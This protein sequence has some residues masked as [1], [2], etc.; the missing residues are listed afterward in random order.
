MFFAL[1]VALAPESA[2]APGHDI[3]Q[4][5]LSDALA[6]I[7]KGRVALAKRQWMDARRAF[8][9]ALRSDPRCCGAHHGLGVVELARGKPTKAIKSLKAALE[10]CAAPAAGARLDLAAAY[11]A[12]G[13]F[14]WALRTLDSL[15]DDLMPSLRERR[16]ILRGLAL[17]DGERADEAVALLEESVPVDGDPALAGWREYALARARLSSGEP[18]GARRALALAVQEPTT[19]PLSEAVEAL[20]ITALAVDNPDE[21]WF[22]ASAATTVELD[23]NALYDPEIDAT[24]DW[25]DPMAGRS[26][27]RAALSLRPLNTGRHLLAADAAFLRSFHFGNERAK[28]LDLTE[29]QGILRYAVRLVDPSA[30]HRLETRYQFG[31]DLLEGGDLLPEPN[32]FVFLEAH[33]GA[34][35]WEVS[36]AESWSVRTR[37]TLTRRTFA[38]QARDAWAQELVTG[39]TFELWDRR[40]RLTAELGLRLDTARRARYDLWGLHGTVRGAARVVWKLETYAALTY[41]FRDHYD[42]R[43]AFD[44][45]A[46]GTSRRD[47]A[48]TASVGLGLPLLSGHLLL[49]LQ[50]RYQAQ[51][52]SISWYDYDRHVVAF[53]LGG[54]S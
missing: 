2:A 20:M 12:A 46:L 22:S 11:L 6:Q 24:R 35:D 33:G 53:L 37:Y 19:K 5:R 17:A 34:L 41:A 3:S 51:I 7:A 21:G 28:Q 29:V 1:F 36:P 42:S 15:P 30:E 48:L 23:T 10:H 16:R 25:P 9:T 43:G 44:H 40:L 14:P 13:N 31:V 27:L 26:S 45:E 32:R 47:H 52:S 8:R 54:R 39:P 49:A 18:R 38:E 50:Y 4:Q